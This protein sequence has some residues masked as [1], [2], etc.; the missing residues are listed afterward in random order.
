ME[1]R[2]VLSILDKEVSFRDILEARGQ[3]KEALNEMSLSRVWQHAKRAGERSWA[4]L[5]SWRYG[6]TNRQNMVQFKKLQ[7]DVRSMGLGFF[8]LK[9]HW[10]ECRRSDIPYK[11]CPKQDLIDSVELSLWVNGISKRDAEKL[12]KK[13]NQDGIVYA[14]P[15]TKGNVYYVL[16]GGADQNIGKFK[17]NK[18]AQGYSE[19]K[20][21]PFVFEGFEYIAQGW[22]EG[23]I[24]QHF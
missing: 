19:L 18:I 8:K 4:I 7:Q 10:K 15:E 5:T 17:P 24:E 9:G 22:V 21:R 3:N 13:Y 23:M 1:P 16:R 14:G 12:M 11:D 2:E 20:G 6:K